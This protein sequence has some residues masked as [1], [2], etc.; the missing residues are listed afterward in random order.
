MLKTIA[1][2]VLGT[3]LVGCQSLATGDKPAAAKLDATQAVACTKCDVTW[4]KTPQEQKGRIV[5]YS[6]RKVM[7]CPD[8]KDAVANYFSTGKLEHACKTCGPDAMQ[9]CQMH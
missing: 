7:E 9:A 3:V 4:V 1:S 5:G 2:I 8:C 6:N